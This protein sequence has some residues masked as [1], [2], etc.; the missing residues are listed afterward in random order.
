MR[1][2]RRQFGVLLHPTSLPGP[3]GI[4]DIGPSAH[5]F[6]DWLKAAG[7]SLWQVLPLGPTGYGDSPYQ[8]FS[9]FA[10]N[11]YLISPELLVK[12][13][14]LSKAEAKPPA[15]PADK[16]DFG[17]VIHWKVGLLQ[18]AFDNHRRKPSPEIAKAIESF[19]RD[20]FIRTWLEDFALFMALKDAHGGAPWNTWRKELR[21]CD[22]AALRAARREHADRIEFHVFLQALFD[23]QWQA[24]RAA[25][26]ERGI[27]LIGDAPIYV[28][29]DS[30]DTWA[31]QHLFKLKANGEPTHVAGVPPDYFSAT[32]QLWGNPIYKWDVMKKTNFAWWKQRLHAV[33][34]QV[35]AVRLDHFRGFEAY[36]QVPFGESTAINGKWVPGPRKDLFAALEKEFGH[37]PIIAEN[38]GVIT[39]DV[40]QLRYDFNLP[41]MKILQFGWGVCSTKPLVPDPEGVHQ[42]YKAD[43][44]D[45]VYTGTHDNPTSRQWWE[46]FAG[47]GE[48]AHFRALLNTTAEKPHEDFIRLALLS[49]ADTV[50]VP[51]QDL[52]G[53]GAEGRMN[54]PGRESGNW[55][56][57]MSAMP[58][59][60]AAQSL[61]DQLLLFGRASDQREV[62]EKMIARQSKTQRARKP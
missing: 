2:D 5:R 3:Y 32:G 10:G 14:L 41:G 19:R 39:P 43:R 59:K 55:A 22:P 34:R 26:K 49:H 58:D 30:A 12:D 16:V 36:W 15:F 60:K 13:G 50:I 11:P 51:M 38:L 24:V 18:R 20:R 27:A 56:W 25:A 42:P 9:A 28:A 35:D 57:R 6:L 47:E 17:W 23:R 33:L 44:T 53:V 29:Y 52:Q 8:S 1:F 37:L 40:E 4:G 45:V 54:F 48:K 21:A 61:H 7:A 62:G 46:E 31:H